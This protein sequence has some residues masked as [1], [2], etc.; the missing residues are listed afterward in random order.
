MEEERRSRKRR[1]S[2]EIR[3]GEEEVD[4]ELEDKGEEVQQEEME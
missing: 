3:M 4:K 2:S 1:G